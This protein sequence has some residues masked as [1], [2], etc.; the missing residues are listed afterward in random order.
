MLNNFNTIITVG[1]K[2]Y[3]IPF[4]CN[5]VGTCGDCGG[6]LIQSIDITN[7]A[8]PITCLCCHKMVKQPL[9]TT[10]GP[11]MEMQKS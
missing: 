10:F 8:G 6:P 9:L 11:V 3:N 1:D 2:Q 4:G 7:G 5:V